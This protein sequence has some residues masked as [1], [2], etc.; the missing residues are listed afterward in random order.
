MQELTRSQPASRDTGSGPGAP[1]ASRLRGG[2]VGFGRMG[3]THFAILNTHPR[4]GFAAI[5]DASQFMRRNVTKYLGVQAFEDY[6]EML[7]KV[8]L[9]FLIVATPTGAHAEVVGRALDRGLHVFVEKPL[10]LATADG[11]RLVAA[12]E[13]AGVV[14]QVGYVV[15]FNDVIMQVKRLL[16]A[17]ALGE[18]IHYKM[19]MYGPTVLKEPAS[20]RGKKTE[21][22]GCLYD[23]ASHSIDLTNHLFGAR[24][25]PCGTVMQRIY[26][27]GVEDAVYTTLVYDGGL[28]GSLLANWS[29]PAHR[30]PSYRLEV[31]GREGKLIAD[32]HAYKVFF[33]GTPPVPGFEK[34]WNTRYVTDFAEPV[35][36]YLRGYEFTRQLDH[37]IDCI[38]EKR[39]TSMCPFAE[40]L[41]TD[42]LM[43]SIAADAM[44][45]DAAHG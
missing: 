12:A 16:D 19:E 6:A 42:R 27:S 44:R 2:L 26:S 36:F 32:L 22:G 37:F 11:E 38:L 17:G 21:G 41:A 30:K 14:H 40:G 45:R 20:W 8:P 10:A 9:D 25:T 31:L 15:R 33:R 24:A 43:E 39:R 29:D 34:G 18:L 5:C 4:V 7:E 13:R 1:A 3:I 35:R 28:H 23:F